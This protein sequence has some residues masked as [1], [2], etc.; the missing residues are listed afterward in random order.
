MDTDSNRMVQTRLPVINSA[1]IRTCSNCFVRAECP[2]FE[3]G[4]SC[5]YEIPIEVRTP[6]QRKALMNGLVELQ[7]QRVA[8]MRFRE[9]LSGGYADPN[10]SQEFDRLLKTFQVQAE[11]EDDREFFRMSV[12]A[13]G[14]SGVLS[15]LFGEKAADLA[16]PLSNQ[17]GA[18]ETD[19]LVGRVIQG[20]AE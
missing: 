16:N 4:A 3:E 15:R 17:L 13:K 14:R 2:A 8:F 20:K 5:S 18:Q 9:E 7:A 10:L 12:E 19:R 1:P 6:S 11:L